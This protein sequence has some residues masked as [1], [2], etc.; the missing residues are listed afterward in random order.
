MIPTG[1]DTTGFAYVNTG[2][3]GGY[4]AT[5]AGIENAVVGDGPAGVNVGA[6]GPCGTS[7][8]DG[9]GN[10]A[11]ESGYA[12]GRG[13]AE[14]SSRLN[15]GMLTRCDLP[16]A[17]K[18]A[19]ANRELHAALAEIRVPLDGHAAPLALRRLL[20]T[21]HLPVDGPTWKQKCA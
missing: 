9:Y 8:Y 21:Q 12:G 13:S 19:F 11:N 5:G 17:A 4:T 20:F 3:G 2:A 18:A 10:G 7:A 6:C 15:S 16:T 14:S 1:P